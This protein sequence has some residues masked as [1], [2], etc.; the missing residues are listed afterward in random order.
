MNYYYY[1]C[2]VILKQQAMKNTKW[3][4]DPDQSEIIFNVRKLMI[5]N[6]QGNFNVFQGELE[7]DSDNFE[8][9]KNIQ[10]EAS[11]DSIKTDDEKR[12]QHLKSSDFFDADKYP[13]LSFTAHSY[14]TKSQKIQ[15]ELSIRNITKPVLLEVASLEAPILEKGKTSAGFSI[16]GKVKRQDFGLGWN[17]KN[18][19]GE[20]IVGDQIK[21]KADLRFIKQP[22]I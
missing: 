10:L 8:H 11:I 12:D 16:S 18:A 1:L 20:I 4:I 7:T 19:A 14:D 21:L 13:T 2:S 17:G 15:G 3:T 5:T 22:Q 9:L 6:V